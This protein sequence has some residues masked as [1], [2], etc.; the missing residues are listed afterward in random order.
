MPRYLEAIVAVVVCS[1]AHAVVLRADVRKVT[2]T[3]PSTPPPP[4]GLDRTRN[5]S[6]PGTQAG[7]ILDAGG[8]S[9]AARGSGGAGSAVS[10]LWSS[11]SKGVDNF[12][13]ELAYDEALLITH[14]K[15]SPGPP[16]QKSK[17]TDAA[18]ASAMPVND[19]LLYFRPVSVSLYCVMILSVQSLLI[20]TGLAFSRNYD[21]L[22]GRLRP[23]MTTETLAV[24]AR[25]ATFSAMLAML[26]VGC[27]MWVLA[28]TNGLGEPPTWVKFSMMAGTAG[29]SL[30]NLIVLM[31]PSVLKREKYGKARKS[32]SETSGTSHDIHPVLAQHDYQSADDEAALWNWQYL[33]MTLMYGGAAGVLAGIMSFPAQMTVMSPAVVGTCILSSLYMLVYLFLWFARQSHHA[34]ALQEGLTSSDKYYRHRGADV[35]Q[36]EIVH[37]DQAKG[38]RAKDVKLPPRVEDARGTLDT[39]VMGATPR[40][41]EGGE[42]DT[43][44]AALAMGAA[45]KKAPILAVLFLA[46]R[47]RALEASPPHGVLPWSAHWCIYVATGALVLE[48][49]VAWRIGATG[50]RETLYYGASLFHADHSLHCLQTLCRCLVYAGVVPVM[51]AV[52]NIEDMD[53]LSTEG[54]PAAL[55][56]M[57]VLVTMFL[58]VDTLQVVALLASDISSMVRDTILAAHVAVN[59]TPLLCILFV[60]ARMR[61]LQITKNKGETPG[62]A[63]ECMYMAVFST[64]VEVACCML[65]P[66]FTNAVTSVDSEGHP[67]YDVRP[68]FAAYFVAILKYVALFFLHGGAL[69]VCASIFSM[70]PETARHEHGAFEKRGDVYR[71][72][73]VCLLF[74]LA[75]LLLSSAKVVGLA[76]KFGIETADEALWGVNVELTDAKLS[77]CEGYV[78]VGGVRVTNPPGSKFTSDYLL[79]VDKVLIKINMWRLAKSF[80]RSF[81]ITAIVLKGL[82]VNVEKPTLRA[83]SNVGLVAQYLDAQKAKKA[84]ASSTTPK[85]WPRNPEMNAK[86]QAAPLHKEAE[87]A[88]AEEQGFLKELLVHKIDVEDIGGDVIPPLGSSFTLKV[89]QLICEDLQLTM[90]QD[91]RTQPVDIVRGVLRLVLQSMLEHTTEYFVQAAK[92]VGADALESATSCTSGL[93]STLGTAAAEV[94]N[95]ATDPGQAQPSSSSSRATRIAV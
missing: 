21:E 73:V 50:R 40:D 69:G 11:F 10:Q 58:V 74:I 32:F 24:A 53:P 30:Q 94:C 47:I 17:A 56:C 49:L 3:S 44:G 52:F 15:A 41:D 84:Q 54:M 88:S 36:E 46:V 64:L 1:S 27:R 71:F 7:D 61:A 66:L 43:L 72:L 5:V 60:A 62:W 93:M 34:K 79:K 85:Q 37:K 20:Y 68:M 80:G 51:A 39:E 81:E 75:A 38:P 67:E 4:T 45:V 8:S 33:A 63:Q 90:P 22:S 95:P 2:G 12:L 23:T 6:H 83:T 77:V 16:L 82:H 59:Y 9:A 26:F 29:C 28:T 19:R 76:I 78:N 87:V 55:I 89:P 92:N 48:T 42:D 35:I 13:R 31:L 14:L 91:R 86:A 70:T 18:R 25:G 57:V 65:M